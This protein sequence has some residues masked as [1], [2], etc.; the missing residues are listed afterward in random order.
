M[1][2]TG[3]SCHHSAFAN[4]TV[5]LG[6]MCV[7]AD[8]LCAGV[9]DEKGACVCERGRR[10][11]CSRISAC[12]W[13]LCDQFYGAAGCW[14][15]KEGLAK[16]KAGAAILKSALHATNLFSCLDDHYFCRLEADAFTSGTAL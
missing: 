16:L 4:I 6:L 7:S 11:R 9:C 14:V 13:R 2:R 12:F 8:M 15:T 3:G 5:R 10:W 1:E